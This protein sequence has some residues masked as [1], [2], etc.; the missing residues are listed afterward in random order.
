MVL[1][2]C[3]TMIVVYGSMCMTDPTV[4][5]VAITGK[6]A[7]TETYLPMTEFCVA[8]ADRLALPDLMR[9]AEVTIKATTVDSISN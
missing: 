1:D 7:V 3:G 5:S 9:L 8:T 2:S 6:L 4:N